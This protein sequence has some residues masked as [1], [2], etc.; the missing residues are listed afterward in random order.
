MGGF[1]P[2]ASYEALM[3]IQ[4]KGLMDNFEY[5]STVSPNTII[6]QDDYIPHNCNELKEHLTFQLSVPK[7]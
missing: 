7:V 3:N 4:L 2:N 6:N 5:T 1:E